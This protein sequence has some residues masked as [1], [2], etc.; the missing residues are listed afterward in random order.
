MTRLPRLT[1]FEFISALQRAGFSNVRVR[2]VTVSRDTRTVA[3]PSF[4]RILAR[5]S[6]PASRPKSC[7][8]AT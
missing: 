6:V 3:R 1:G 7:E 2:A 5:L 8:T 4:R